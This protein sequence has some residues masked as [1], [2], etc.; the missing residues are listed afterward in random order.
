MSMTN[1]Y[2]SGLGKDILLDRY[3]EL[4]SSAESFVEQGDRERAAEFYFKAADVLEKVAELEGDEELGQKRRDLARKTRRAA[5]DL[6]DNDKDTSQATESSEDGASP[7][8]L[9]EWSVENPSLDFRDMPGMEDLKEQFKWKVIDPLATPEIYQRMDL[10]VVNGFILHG[11]PG[12]GKTHSIKCLA[13]ELGYNFLKGDG[14]ELISRYLGSSAD[15]IKD[16]FGTALQVEPSMVFIDE[17]DAVAP[18]RTSDS[19]QQNQGYV[20]ATNQLLQELS[21]IQGSEVVFV[22]ATNRLEAVDEAVKGSHRVEEVI[23]VGLPD[24][25]ARQEILEYYL[26]GRPV[27]EGV[28]LPR[29]VRETEGFSAGDLETLVDSASRKAVKRS[30]TEGSQDMDVEVRE[31]DLEVAVREIKE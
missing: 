3:Q 17:L 1:G 2:S 18:S 25:G 10:T 23:E 12:T 14:A 15:S 20:E 11:P 8:G 21:R 30:K 13:G 9:G 7:A 28:D 26:D 19:G 6:K 22:G 16:L 4:K 24:R 27:A 5:V 29:F 31:R